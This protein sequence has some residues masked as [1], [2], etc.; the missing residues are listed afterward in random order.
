MEEVKGIKIANNKNVKNVLI[1][2][3]LIL[4]VTVMLF[5]WLAL[6]G[7]FGKNTVLNFCRD[8]C[9]VFSKES[10]RS[11]SYVGGL[12][13][14]DFVGKT[15]NS[16]SDKYNVLLEKYDENGNLTGR[17]YDTSF[18]FFMLRD[19]DYRDD[20]YVVYADIQDGVISNIMLLNVARYDA[21]GDSNTKNYEEDLSENELNAYTYWNS[22]GGLGVLYKASKWEKYD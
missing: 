5:V 13:K 8:A 14:A 16:I 1:K 9:F 18:A 7:L 4:S 21:V 3:L 6:L 11:E 15:E 12:A 2:T 17:Y 20:R 19:Y 10:V 22:N